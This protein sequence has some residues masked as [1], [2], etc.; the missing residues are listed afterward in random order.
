MAKTT[1]LKK[2]APA[3]TKAVAKTA[4]TKPAA[5]KESQTN[6]QILAK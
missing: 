3:K 2:A 5:A 1:T 6:L 4:A